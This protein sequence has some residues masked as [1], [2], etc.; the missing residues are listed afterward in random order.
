MFTNTDNMTS[1]EVLNQITHDFGK[2]SWDP[3]L[4]KNAKKVINKKLKD[5]NNIYM[6][7]LD[8]VSNFL[9][10]NGKIPKLQ[11]I[12]DIN[13]Y[14]SKE[15][16]ELGTWP[17]Q[18][19]DFSVR[20]LVYSDAIPLFA[21]Q[22]MGCPLG[23][24]DFMFSG[25]TLCH[26][27][28]QKLKYKT[29]V[30]LLHVKRNIMILRK[31]NQTP[32][33]KRDVGNAGCRFERFLTNEGYDKEWNL[34]SNL[35]VRVLNVGRYK[36]LIVGQIDCVDEN[37][38]PVEIKI[39]EKCLKGSVSKTK[40]LLQMISN[41]SKWLVVGNDHLYGTG[42]SLKVLSVR[43]MSL[44]QLLKNTNP[45]WLCNVFDK[46]LLQLDELKKMQMTG[47]IPSDHA[48][49]N[50]LEF[51]NENSIK[52]KRIIVKPFFEKKGTVEN[53]SLKLYETLFRSDSLKLLRKFPIRKDHV[54]LCQDNRCIVC[55]NWAKFV[56]KFRVICSYT[57]V[58][59]YDYLI[60]VRFV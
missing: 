55:N 48:F 31:Y 15:P 46:V 26:L 10:L 16:V 37:G 30:E 27:Y 53:Y 49:F 57:K 59:M 13:D 43:K 58:Y 29:D 8:D 11:N 41:G 33:D 6:V 52:R 38:D 4:N 50:Q 39:S 5:G 19:V 28:E 22:Q 7:T 12:S 44:E 40:T 51:G 14:L 1:V 56:N 47:E 9:V 60:R 34:I 23:E 17:R 36:I 21:A 45:A 2:F 54:L 18:I 35:N 3:H 32:R 20:P 25:S 24:I 42:K